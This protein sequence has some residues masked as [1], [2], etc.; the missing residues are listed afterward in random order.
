MSYG[1]KLTSTSEVEN[2]PGFAMI[3]GFDLADKFNEYAAHSGIKINY[4]DIKTLDL[5]EKTKKIV[6]S[7]GEIIEAKAV[8]IACGI[9]KRK[10]GVP[11]EQEFAGRG[12][13][14]CA[15][16]DGNFFRNKKVI[17]CGGG[18]SAVEDA[19]YL[20]NI[21]SEVVVIHRRDIFTAE[22]ILVDRLQSKKNVTYLMKT[23]I[24]EIY[25]DEKVRGVV[26]EN[27]DGRVSVEADA[28]FAAVGSVPNTDFIASPPELD[29]GGYIVTD[30]LM[31]TSIPGVFAAGDIRSFPVKQIVTA[32]SDGAVAVK[33][34]IE[35]LHSI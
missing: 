20:S 3:S 14:Y 22:K 29:A 30:T 31:A 5:S 26:T 18:N 2:Y 28:V 23:V 21:C 11:G 32:A 34:V 33:G 27:A 17:V 13:S 8:I 6:T 15:V 9:N 7:R 12:V 24:K 19:E 10:L 1:G 4:K 16:C 35:Y 25:G